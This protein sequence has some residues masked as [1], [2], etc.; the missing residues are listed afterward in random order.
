MPC[1]YYDAVERAESVAAA[2]LGTAGMQRAS[3]VD[4]AAA[5]DFIQAAMSGDKENLSANVRT[6]QECAAGMSD[7]ALEIVGKVM[8]AGGAAE[9]RTQVQNLN[10]VTLQALQEQLGCM[11]LEHTPGR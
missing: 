6:L 9:C 2:A 1:R 8:G 4:Q 10:G 11:G 5:R 7:A 3:R